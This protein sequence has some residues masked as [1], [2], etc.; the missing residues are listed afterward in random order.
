MTFASGSEAHPHIL[1]WRVAG[2]VDRVEDPL[3]QCE[4]VVVGGVVVD[5]G[6][7]P[8]GADGGGRDDVGLPVQFE[9]GS[10]WPSGLIQVIV[11]RHRVPYG[12]G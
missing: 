9:E 10:S 1:S 7:D 8:V 5:G 11:I 2:I 4:V 3:A 12:S 6:G